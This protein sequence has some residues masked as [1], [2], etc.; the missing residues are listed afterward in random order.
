ML[1]RPPS[2]VLRVTAHWAVLRAALGALLFV[3]AGRTD[4]RSLRTYL[5]TFSGLLLA[6]MLAARPDLVEERFHTAEAKVDD[7]ARLASGFLFLVTLTAAAL[8]VGRLHASD[9]L[10]WA[11]RMASLITFALAALTQAWAMAVNPFFSPAV[12]IQ[13]ERGHHLVTGGPYRTIRHPGYLA[14]LISVPASALAIG[15]WLAL[16]PG[17]TFSAVIIRRAAIEDNFLKVNLP[18][19]ATYGRAVR[20]RLV[21]SIW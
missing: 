6:T 15:S 20:S 1:K 12:R 21:P 13:A 17:L 14:M 7:E 5:L 2:H 9:T 16:I 19:Y 8:D 11:V 4:I 10:P 18:G 3:A